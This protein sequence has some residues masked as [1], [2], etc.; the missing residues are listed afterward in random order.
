VNPAGS[1]KLASQLLDLTLIDSEGCYCGIVDDIELEGTAGQP[2]R[3]VALLVGP[4]AYAG[5]LP[6]WVMRLVRMVAGNRVVRV[7]FQKVRTISSAV[8]LSC[9]AKDV[10]LGRSEAAARRWI[11]RKGAL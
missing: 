1:I 5:R 6:L 7:P 2:I 4:G 11:P 3:L 8:R 10:S 9:P